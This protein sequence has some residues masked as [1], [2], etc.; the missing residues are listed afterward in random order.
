MHTALS[1]FSQQAA[2]AYFQAAEAGRGRTSWLINSHHF[3]RDLQ[4]QLIEAGAV[5]APTSMPSHKDY[6][7][8]ESLDLFGSESIHHRMLIIRC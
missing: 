2:L 8:G 1:G 7:Q 6:F 4:L 5:T 3:G